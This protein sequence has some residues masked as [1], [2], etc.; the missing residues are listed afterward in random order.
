MWHHRQCRDDRNATPSS[1]SW[2]GFYDTFLTT[3]IWHRRQCCDIYFMTHFRS[4]PVWRLVTYFKYRTLPDLGY[5]ELG[6]CRDDKNMTPSSCKPLYIGMVI[7]TDFYYN[8]ITEVGYATGLALSRVWWP[9]CDYVI[10]S[11]QSICYLNRYIHTI[12][13]I[14]G[15]AIDYCYQIC[16]LSIS[17][18]C[19]R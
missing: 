3:E 15:Y 13:T 14:S 8:K 11:S 19:Y 17:Y 1:V 2:Y 7:L 10:I 4:I 16:M 5:D 9:D 18:K 6:M 12:Y